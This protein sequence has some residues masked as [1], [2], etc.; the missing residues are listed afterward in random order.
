MASAKTVPKPFSVKA[1]TVA[2]V[3]TYLANTAF[4][5][6]L[7]LGCL[8]HYKRIVKNE[9]AGYPDEWFPSVSA[10]IGD[11]YPERNIFQILI[12]L[13]AGP[14]FAV[15]FL[16]Y[17]LAR[18]KNSKLAVVVLISGLVRTVSCGGWVYITSSDDHDVHDFFMV[19]YIVCNIPWMFGGLA[20]TPSDNHT[21]RRRRQLVSGAFFGSLVP[22]VYFFIQHKVH[23][24][25]GAY[26]RYAFCE[27]SLIFCDIAYDSIAEIDFRRA[28]L[29]VAL[30]VSLRSTATDE[31]LAQA[32]AM[33]ETP[34]EAQAIVEDN[35]EA[36]N[37]PARQDVSHSW[38]STLAIIVPRPL[39]AF[40]SD[41]YLA[42]VFWS[43]YT[44][45]VP[46]L[47]YF[48]IWELAIAGSEIALLSCL[49]PVIL[50][51]PGALPWAASRDGQTTLR[52]LSLVG[53][54]VYVVNSPL[55]RLFGV[56]FANICLFVGQAAEWT[57]TGEKSVEYSAILT[58]LGLIISSVTK[59]ANHTNNPIWPFVNE[60]S[61][62]YNKTG[63]VLA[64]LALY[65][66]HTRPRLQEEPT[67]S[68][69]KQAKRTRLPASREFGPSG[70]WLTAAV[71]GGSLVYSLHTFLSESSTLI[72]WLWTGYPITGPVPHLHGAMTIIAQ[73]FGLLIPLAL[74]GSGIGVDV[75]L[76]PV[77]FAY[78][79]ASAYT[80]YSY[81][82]WVGYFGGLNLA[83]YLMSVIPPV[84]L[85]LA[86][87]SRGREGKTF[88]S[89]FVVVCMLDLASVWTVAY[90]FVPGG[91]YLRERTDLVLIAQMSGLAL[92]A[93]WPNGQG[94]SSLL[95][96]PLHAKR[97]ASAVLAICSVLSVIA[98]L[99][100]LPTEPPRPYRPAS[101][102]IRA[103]IWTVHFGIDNAGRDSQRGMRHLIHDMELDIVGLLE[104]D[105]HRIVYGNRD[106]TRVIAEQ[107]GY[108]VDIGPGPNQHTW[109]CVL[110][111]KF[112]IVNSTHHLLPSPEGEL[113]PAIEAIIDVWGTLVTAVVAHNGQEETPLDRE[114]QA[115][116][117]A[118]IMSASYPRPV[119]FLG[120]VVTKPHAARPSPYEIMV[121]DGQVHD[122][123]QEDE[124]RWCEYIFYRGL[125]RTSYS[126]L[127]RG[128]I[129]D[130]ELQV[131]QFVVPRIGSGPINDTVEARYLRSFKEDLPTDHW[132]PM[133]YY[134]DEAGGGVNGHFY[135]VFYTPLYYKIPEGSE[136]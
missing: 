47:F 109:G 38:A 32:P 123:D 23:R 4:L 11:W 40:L 46:T 54:A 51:I 116:E 80:L 92:I 1:T 104:T 53:L 118:R 105:L 113:A 27:W 130:T 93:R 131:G 78:G 67:S 91:A 70:T 43:I 58:G 25:P 125:Y 63:I 100:R 65:E 119:I 75:L 52:A 136:V 44:S 57:G 68:N 21:A 126:R 30:G 83:I 31:I 101:R 73:C 120:Y 106:L 89:A 9:V 33:P 107:E 10:T 50:G 94:A 36:D 133:E 14:R 35:A 61:G 3:H 71:A 129:T 64:C 24:I 115:T 62:G 22:L 77:W 37:Q 102:I 41:A 79:T 86:R 128:S 135:H 98:T 12:A 29:E 2:T 55:G 7:A 66:A 112:P 122:I 90:A 26:T 81:K 132:F 59:L 124:D 121:Q 82:N 85:E 18:T 84:L 99:Y 88:F 16:Q 5:T 8:L 48:S 17:Y 56:A 95:N 96:T 72:A 87:A 20:C 28:E 97:Y 134:G 76:H 60:N 19:T 117:L 13:T 103:G 110:L 15:V 114:L 39:V 45:L 127:S 6:A 111:S 49:S 34:T 42:Y 69:A 74:K 108:Y